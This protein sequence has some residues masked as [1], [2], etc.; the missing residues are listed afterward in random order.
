MK[1]M[2]MGNIILPA[3]AEK[4]SL[5]P[6]Y[7][8][9]WLVGLSRR[10]TQLPDV[11]LTYVFDAPKALTGEVDGYRYYGL[12]NPTR[13]TQR[14]GEAYTRQLEDILRK[15][16]PNVIH[17]WGTENQHTLA[18]VDAAE[19]M[20]MRER[21]VISIQGLLS[22]YAEHYRAYLPEHVCHGHTLKDLV[23][24]N[25]IRQEAIYRRVGQYEQ[26][27]LR[28][29]QHVIGRTDW[30]AAC[31]AELAPQAAYHFN[32]ETL[33]DEFYTGEWSLG[34]CEPYS[35]FC[36]QAHVPLK[37]L[38]LLLQAL[39]IVRKRH[40][41][42]KLYVGRKDYGRIPPLA[43][44]A[45]ERYI[46]RLLR[47]NDLYDHVVFTGSLNA[48]Q[49]KERYLKS[50]VFVLP[51]SIENSPNSLGEAMLLG[52]P[53]IA[54]DVGGVRCLMTHGV[55]GLI[56]PADDPHLLAYDICEMFAHPEKAAQMARAGRE[57]AGKTHDAQK[58]LEILHQIY[59]EIAR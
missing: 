6:V 39:A 21:I 25:I 43:R 36:S 17:L 4:E 42:V 10:L 33:R 16:Q 38:H 8:V 9:G 15:E 35:I 53:C 57:H 46:H 48:Q 29:V 30:D 11:A 59:T 12:V 1:V 51:S 44:N 54:S 24:G 34:S 23:K 18:M 45:Y 41:D 52:V 37:G 22:I 2:W 31:M 28:R 32:N 7:I 58:N 19:H 13:P 49:M 3:I 56:Y 14:C 26:E 47:E 5:P 50:Q 20:G 55:E 40:P 27:A